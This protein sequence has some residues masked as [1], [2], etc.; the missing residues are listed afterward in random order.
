MALVGDDEATV[1][2]FFREDGRVRLQPENETM[3]PMYPDQVAMLGVV[4]GVL[5]RL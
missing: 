1:K 5:R 2:R 4:R 3:E